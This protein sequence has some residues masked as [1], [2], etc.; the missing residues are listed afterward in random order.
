M[1]ELKISRMGKG[2]L[3]QYLDKMSPIFQTGNLPG[4]IPP[5]K[6]YSCHDVVSLGEIRGSINK[7][8][9]QQIV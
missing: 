4:S 8:A 9:E 6:I 1:R 5:S 3:L 2:L 7:L